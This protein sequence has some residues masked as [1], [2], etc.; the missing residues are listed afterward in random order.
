[1][2]QWEKRKAETGIE[3]VFDAFTLL[4]LLAN[5]MKC[6]IMNTHVC[7]TPLKGTVDD[8]PDREFAL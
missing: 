2:G 4:V 8:I 7:P 1:V 3:N 5:R 6:M